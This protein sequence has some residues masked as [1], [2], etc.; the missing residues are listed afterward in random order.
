MI[1]VCWNDAGVLD[2]DGVIHVDL[3]VADGF[4][5]SSLCGPSDLFGT[6]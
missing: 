6:E 3:T 2:S 4:L 5:R 1:N